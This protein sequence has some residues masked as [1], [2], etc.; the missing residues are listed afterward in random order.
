MSGMPMSVLGSK[1]MQRV[2]PSP[3]AFRSGE[4][5]LEKEAPVYAKLLQTQLFSEMM[6]AGPDVIPP[7]RYDYSALNAFALAEMEN[8]SGTDASERDETNQVEQ[9]A[10]DPSGNSDDAGAPEDPDGSS[11]EGRAPQAATSSSA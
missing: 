4:Q 6:S 3:H 2:T 10:G 7:M 5:G 9:S 1:L 8:A 11:E